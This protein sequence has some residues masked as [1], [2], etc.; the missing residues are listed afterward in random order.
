MIISK[1]W[2]SSLCFLTKATN[3]QNVHEILIYLFEAK[4][5]KGSSRASIISIFLYLLKEKVRKG[6]L[7]KI[8]LKE[9]NTTSTSK[10]ILKQSME[11]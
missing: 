4:S 10:R 7:R 2:S 6:D 1:L 5:K 11:A 8:Q 9:K 3:S